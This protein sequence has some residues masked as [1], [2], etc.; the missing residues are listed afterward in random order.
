MILHNEGEKFLYMGTEY[1]VGGKVIATKETEYEGLVGKIIEIRD[2]E[3]KETDNDTPDIYCCFAEP[4]MSVNKEKLKKRFSDLWQQPMEIEDINL[5]QPV[6]APDMIIPIDKLRNN[7]D[8]KKIYVLVEDA[9]VDGNDS[10]F[11]EAFTDYEEAKKHLEIRLNDEMENGMLLTPMDSKDFVVE[12]SADSYEIYRRGR[13]C[14]WHYSVYIHEHE[15]EL[16]DEFVKEIGGLYVDHVFTED[17]ESEAEG[18]EEFEDFT[19]EEF[20]AFFQKPEI[21]ERVRA[22]LRADEIFMGEYFRV[23]SEVA[24]KMIKEEMKKRSEE[25][26]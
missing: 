24:H 26:I 8:K 21:P 13:Y 12:E 7:K 18:W 20:D 14:E 25:N 5:D 17:F 16:S 23:I 6:M 22:E 10:L 2:G 4:V 9:A 11:V 15:A 19:D 3:D 1:V